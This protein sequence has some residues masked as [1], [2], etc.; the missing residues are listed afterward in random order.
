MS[1]R[2]CIFLIAAALAL[3]AC[4]NKGDLILPPPKPAKP[5]TPPPA[6]ASDTTQKPASS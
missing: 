1:N 4:G 3:T 5:Q 2:H 6:P